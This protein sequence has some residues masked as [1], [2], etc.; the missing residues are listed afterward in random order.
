MNHQNHVKTHQNHIKV[1]GLG[2]GLEGWGTLFLEFWI[3]AWNFLEDPKIQW[4]TVKSKFVVASSTPKNAKKDGGSA[5]RSFVNEVI[6]F[7]EVDDILEGGSPIHLGKMDSSYQRWKCGTCK[8][9]RK[10]GKEGTM[11]SGIQLQ[12]PYER[13]RRENLVPHRVSPRLPFEDHWDWW[14]L[15]EQGCFSEW[16]NWMARMQCPTRC[17][18]SSLYHCGRV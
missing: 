3:P 5:N 11:T 13:V 9:L 14:F 4:N 1:R 10:E 6:V 12:F 16:Q 8:N 2:G 15:D 18:R 17:C 7:T